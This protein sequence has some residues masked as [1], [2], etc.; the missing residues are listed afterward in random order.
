MP[1]RKPVTV[2]G[3]ADDR[4]D[5]LGPEARLA[6]TDAEVVVANARL[7]AL[8]QSWARPSTG[9][10]SMLEVGPDSD[11]MVQQVWSQSVEYARRVCVLAAGDPGFFGVAR[12]LLR[13]IDRHQLI[14]LPG[15]SSVS[16]AFARVALPWDDAV[17]VSA[18]SRP[19][20]EIT[21][22]VRTAS[23]VAVLTSP[24]R[25]PEVIGR[26]L[27]EAGVAVD[28]AA[29][30]SQLGTE[31]ESVE[32]LSLADLATGSFDPHSVL[33]LVG[34]GGLPLIGWAA[35]KA[36]E[37]NPLANLA[38]GLPDGAFAHRPVVT[39][40]EVRAV[41]LGKLQLPRAGVLW[42][43]GA[44]GTVGIESAL[45]RPGLTVMA[46]EDSPEEAAQVAASAAAL[47]AGVHVVT[48]RAPEVLE[49]L[50]APD[51]VFVGD[52]ALASLEAA[53]ARL[54]PGGRIVASFASL[55]QA[56]A[57]ASTLGNLVQIGAHHGER[58]DDGG[59]RLVARDL[60]FVAWGPGIDD[61]PDSPFVA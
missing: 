52:G 13:R 25:P 12:A 43:V 46:V 56:A 58:L 41:V 27:L 48:G 3:V 2:V 10:P 31:T 53:L 11:D 36:A 18:E 55:D 9:V 51:R 34:P 45:V 29:V 54:R 15:A 38:W 59:W 7:L 50:P 24:E 5:L 57:A 21:S 37:R 30:C 16:L 22:A 8:W 42:D 39:K 60:L 35:S 6:L 28:L 1:D 23:K 17:V 47:G 32:E 26:S 33:I 14:I 44:G 49:G 61:E 19:L 40:A 4:L 20:D